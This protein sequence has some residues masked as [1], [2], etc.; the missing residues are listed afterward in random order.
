MVERASGA[1]AALLRGGSFMLIP[2]L[3]A[4]ARDGIRGVVSIMPQAAA[5]AIHAG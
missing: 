3:P 1:L 5:T 4:G 2:P